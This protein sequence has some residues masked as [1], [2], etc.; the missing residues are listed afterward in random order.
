MHA[1]LAVILAAILLLVA[2][3]LIVVAVRRN[4]WRGTPAS[5]RERVSIYVPISVCV[6][7]AGVLLLSH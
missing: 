5:L 2:V 1:S 6:S 3:A 7:L 4:G